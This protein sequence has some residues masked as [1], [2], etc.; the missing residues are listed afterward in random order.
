MIRVMFI[1][2]VNARARFMVRVRAGAN[3]GLVL[4]VGFG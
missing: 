2:T 4:L 1:V 3:S